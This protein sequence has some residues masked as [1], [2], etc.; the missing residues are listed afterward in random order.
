LEE[1]GSLAIAIT[2]SLILSIGPSA[3]SFASFEKSSAPAVSTMQINIVDPKDKAAENIASSLVEAY[4]MILRSL[5]V[6]LIAV[7]KAISA[8]M[9]E[10]LAENKLKSIIER[11]PCNSSS[12]RLLKSLSA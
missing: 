12:L 8:V 2:L 11:E 7:S 10:W 4:P 9:L 3:R 1:R 6:F 5:P